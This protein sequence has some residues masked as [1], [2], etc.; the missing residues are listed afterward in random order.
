[1]ARFWGDERGTT[2]IEYALIVSLVFLAAVTSITAFGNKT[3]SI[4]Q[5]VSTTIVAAI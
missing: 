1:L 4:V 5:Y 2:A 3:T